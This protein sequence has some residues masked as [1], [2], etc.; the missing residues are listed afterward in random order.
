MQIT[1]DGKVCA[2]EK[3][4]FLLAVTRRNGIT[5]PTLCHHPGLSGQGC[6]RVCIAEVVEDGWSRTVVS[7]VY[8]I[9]RECEVRTN[10]ETIARSRRVIISLLQARAP[11]SDVIARMAKYYRVQPN[12]RLIVQPGERCILCGLCVRACRELGCGAISTV[13]RGVTKKI[14]TPYEEPSVAC[15]GCGSCANV[16]PTGAIPVEQDAV[17]RRIWNREFDLARCSGCHAVLGTV[18]QLAYGA[19]KAGQDVIPLCDS[20]KKSR[21]ALAMKQTYRQR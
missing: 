3:G 8:P 16:C 17:H 20:C 15:I 21:I 18:D 13:N 11:G 1:I 12:D 19:G 14:A 6:C 9:D 4:E 10:S 5:V 2:C 7:C